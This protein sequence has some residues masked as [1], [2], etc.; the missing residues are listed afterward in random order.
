MTAN[1]VVQVL[2]P[3][4]VGVA[5]EHESVTSASSPRRGGFY[6]LPGSRP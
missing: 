1:L 6:G 3:K 5:L 2:Q 4:L